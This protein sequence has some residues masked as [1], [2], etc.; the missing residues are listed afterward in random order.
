MS[1]LQLPAH[2]AVYSRTGDFAYFNQLGHKVSLA[3][4]DDAK[5]FTWLDAMTARIGSLVPGA[6]IVEKA[7][8][9]PDSRTTPTLNTAVYYDT[10]DYRVLRSGA[11]IRTSC[12]VVT[13]AFCAFK[14]AR[15]AHGVRRDHRYMFDGEE[16]AII[17]RAPTSPEAVA[18]VSR[19][20]ARTD[21]EHP[22]LY[23]HRA[24]NIDPAGLRPS[25]VLERYI[26]SFFAWLDGK[27]AL[28]CPMDRCFVQNLRVPEGQRKTHAFK[29]VE[30]VIYPHIHPDNI[31][32]PRVVELIE[33]LST[34]VCTELGGVITTD[35]KYQR[36]AR[37]LGLYA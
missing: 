14:A 17:Q 8:G 36:G 3:G 32:D 25:I 4:V 12:N 24:H 31:R 11:L 9:K 6:K 18:I 23:L 13:H 29:E 1:E 2:E 37:A 21:T 20:L 22:G 5:Y 26:C 30:I 16:K 10:P 34:S 7:A 15:N 33:V 19:L 27:D 28:R 35:I